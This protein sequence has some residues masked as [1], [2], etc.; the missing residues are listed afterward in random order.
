MTQRGSNEETPLM[1][2]IRLAVCET[3]RATL[4]R[5]SSGFDKSSRV[6]Y[7]LGDGGAD[8]IGFVFKT[9]KFFALEV[10]TATGRLQEN[11]R[12]WIEFV[13]RNGGFASMVRSVEEALAALEKAEND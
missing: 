2:A 9:G 8:L 11:Q 3:G 13:N 4:W 10:K 7:G 12:L 5:N 6:K 1:R